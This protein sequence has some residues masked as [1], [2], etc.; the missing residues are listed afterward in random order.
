MI[1]TNHFAYV[2]FLLGKSQKKN[3]YCAVMSCHVPQKHFHVSHFTKRP[4][5]LAVEWQGDY[6]I[7]CNVQVNW[8][9]QKL[10]IGICNMVNYFAIFS[11][12]KR[13]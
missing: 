2:P 4:N 12:L 7:D 5:Y 3:K 6:Y 9:T 13:H 10:H 1:H 11:V 8:K